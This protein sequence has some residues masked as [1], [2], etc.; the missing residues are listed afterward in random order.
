MMK[1]IAAF[2]VAVP[3]AVAPIAATMSTA[4]ADEVPAATLKIESTS[5]GAGVGVTWGK[6]SLTL[7][8]GMTYR[9]SLRGLNLAE[10]GVT[11]I[12][13][14]GEV[15]NLTK[16]SQFDGTYTGVSA[17]ATVAGG[18]GILRIRNES[19]VIIV[20]KTTSRGLGLKLATEGIRIQLEKAE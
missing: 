13:A 8:N 6:G 12:S 19:G 11:K 5:I 2:F 15:Y 16:L 4:V 14:T 1:R 7:R 3:L 17:S 20:L 10:A 18:R 9:F